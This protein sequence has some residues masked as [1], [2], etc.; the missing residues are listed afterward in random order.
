MAASL[1]SGNKCKAPPQQNF[2]DNRYLNKENITYLV[3]Y[4]FY[5]FESIQENFTLIKEFYYNDQK[6]IQVWFR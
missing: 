1:L 4:K 6:I 3:D 2:N 5:G